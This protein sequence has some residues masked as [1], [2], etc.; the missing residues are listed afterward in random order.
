[1]VALLYRRADS[2]ERGR[3]LVAARAM[4]AGR[5]I[6]AERP[7]LALQTLE[8]RPYCSQVCHGCKAFV[9]GPDS[10]LLRRVSVQQNSTEQQPPPNTNTDGSSSNSGCDNV[11]SYTV[12]PC[13][14]ACGHVYCSADCEGD[15][16]VA[17]HAYL[18]TGDCTSAQHPLVQF[19]QYAVTTN[20]ILLLTAEWWVAQHS[21]TTAT[22]SSSS[23]S[24]AA[25]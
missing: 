7:L 21:T 20:E 25:E 14:A 22:N 6:L 18:C 19:K 3:H 4:E 2:S 11:A 15:T 12:V 24:R 16:W 17:H 13:R 23:S 8:N 1:M 9:G 10:N 5:L